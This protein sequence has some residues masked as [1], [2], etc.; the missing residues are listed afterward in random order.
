LH[1]RG[2]SKATQSGNVPLQDGHD[3]NPNLLKEDKSMK[4]ARLV[5]ATLVV[6]FASIFSQQNIC[7]QE[8]PAA[9]HVHYKEPAEQGVSPTGALAPHLQSWAAT[10]F[11]SPPKIL[12][13]SSS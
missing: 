5:F 6:S 1:G 11:P 7:A 2:S 9:G 4:Y 3:P 13:R 8:K 12:R 10:P